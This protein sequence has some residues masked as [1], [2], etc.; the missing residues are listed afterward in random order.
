MTHSHNFPKYSANSQSAPGHERFY[1]LLVDL[2]RL[3]E[4]LHRLRVAPR[5]EVGHALRHA[6]TNGTEAS[7]SSTQRTA[8]CLTDPISGV[9]F[10]FNQY[11]FQDNSKESVEL[12]LVPSI[13]NTFEYQLI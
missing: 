4:V 2:Q 7:H 8:Q 1:V 13:G 3:V 11:S 9:W 5:L 6:A 12:E 10:R